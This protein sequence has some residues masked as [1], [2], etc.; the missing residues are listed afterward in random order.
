MLNVILRLVRQWRIISFHKHVPRSS[1]TLIGVNLIDGVWGQVNIWS[2][3]EASCEVQEL[4][5]HRTRLCAVWML[6]SSGCAHAYTSGLNWMSLFKTLHTCI[7]TQVQMTQGVHYVFSPKYT[8]THTHRHTTLRLPSVFV[9]CVSG[10]S[11]RSLSMLEWTQ[12]Y[13]YTLGNISLKQST[14]TEARPR[15][16]A[17]I[18]FTVYGEGEFLHKHRNSAAQNCL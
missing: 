14:D 7:C 16:I 4:K 5:S 13:K 12:S 18:P 2:R 6:C 3:E 8:Y 10:I 15:F 17:K 1:L 9:G 11:D